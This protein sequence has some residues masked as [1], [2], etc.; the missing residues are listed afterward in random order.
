MMDV[1]LIKKKYS[2]NAHF[3]DALLGRATGRLLESAGFQVTAQTSILF[4][5][6]W[7]RML[8]LWC[9]TRLP[10]LATLTGRPVRPFAGLY[11][12]VL[13]GQRTWLPDRMRRRQ[14]D[15]S[16]LGRSKTWPLSSVLG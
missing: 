7:L 11:R 8:N 2:R 15:R 9:H 12:W 3:C 1:Q 6:G 5:P 13:N 16:G 14:T 10:P 4:L